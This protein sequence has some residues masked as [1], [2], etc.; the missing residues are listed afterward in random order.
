VAYGLN[1]KEATFV[2]TIEER[3]Q[4]LEREHEQ[5]QTLKREHSELKKTIELQTIAIRA[6]VSKEAF[7]KLQNTVEEI[8]ATAEKSQ[9]QNG[10]LFDVLNNH[11]IFTNERFGDIQTQLV[12]LDGKI[13]GQQTEM[14]QHFSEQD[15]KIVGL[16]T[17]M[18]QRFS[19]QDGKIA[20]LQ[21]TQAEHTTL[22]EQH[23]MMLQEILN[24]LP[25]R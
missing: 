17:E 22:L 6:L 8:Q 9:E 21:E 7:E 3:L 5:L 1:T 14:R 13:I 24:R 11:N 10:K 12:E 19:E 23:T 4:A 15:G 25:E 18:R 20:E 16:Q 2:A